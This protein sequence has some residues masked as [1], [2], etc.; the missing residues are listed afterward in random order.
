[1]NAQL[2]NLILKCSLS[3]F[4][5]HYRTVRLLVTFRNFIIL[6]D[7]N[8]TQIVEMKVSGDHLQP[9]AISGE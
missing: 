2:L 4:K 3:R 6:Y 7:F 5:I 8:D 9:L 1:M